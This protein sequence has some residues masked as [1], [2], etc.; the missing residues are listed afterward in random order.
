MTFQDL[1]VD[2]MK[3]RIAPDFGLG[4]CFASD[5]KSLIER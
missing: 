2:L 5:K 4:S 1:V 3:Q